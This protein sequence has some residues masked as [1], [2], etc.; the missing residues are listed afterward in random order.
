MCSVKSRVLYEDC[1][2]KVYSKWSSAKF[3]IAQPE[4][5]KK[6]TKNNRTVFTA[7]WK[8]VNGADS[9][10]IYLGK[11]AT[12]GVVKIQST[13]KTTFAI[14]KTKHSKSNLASKKYY[15][16]VAKGKSP[17]GKTIRSCKTK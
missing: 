15:C 10:D 6:K 5:V 13:N 16:I 9:Y 1:G 2:K 12:K 4:I 14:S 3:F 8:P 11:S 17:D 7:T